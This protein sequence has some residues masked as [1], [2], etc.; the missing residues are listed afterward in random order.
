M[1]ILDDNS[2]FTIERSFDVANGITEGWFRTY[3]SELANHTSTPEDVNC[4]AYL[5]SDIEQR[6]TFRDRKAWID[7]VLTHWRDIVETVIWQNGTPVV[8]RA[9]CNHRLHRVLLSVRADIVSD[10]EQTFEQL[11]KALSL[12]IATQKSYRY[13]R[14]SLE[15]E[16]GNWRPDYFASGIKQIA[17]FLGPGPNVPEA[18][19]KSF[20]GDIEELTPVL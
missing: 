20:K 8:A 14:A 2:T 13:R 6:A 7:Y 18:Y 5:G 12:E 16:I 19:A 17:A 4:Q 3:V 15:F 11:R 9:S 1:P 10:V